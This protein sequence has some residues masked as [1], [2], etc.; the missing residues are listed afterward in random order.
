MRCGVLVWF[1]LFVFSLLDI[2][3]EIVVKTVKEPGA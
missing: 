2:K 3:D 1:G